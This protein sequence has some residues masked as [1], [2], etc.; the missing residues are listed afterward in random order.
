[1]GMR[2][3]P[4]ELMERARSL[5]GEE[6]PER[7]YAIQFS[8]CDP[9]NRLRDLQSY[10]V[11]P[12]LFESDSASRLHPFTAGCPSSDLDH[13][14]VC[15]ET[16]IPIPPT[17][18]GQFHLYIIIPT[19]DVHGARSDWQGFSGPRTPGFRAFGRRR[20]AEMPALS[21]NHL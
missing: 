17:Q 7:A 18:E 8:L 19:P 1:M 5:S 6:S 9:E 3:P 12:S 20:R 2:Q 21:R 10:T 4:V 11:S 15:S 13:F 14:C 16:R